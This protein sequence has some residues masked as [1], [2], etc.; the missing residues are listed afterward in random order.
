MQD[1]AAFR[2]K[3]KSGLCAKAA[4]MFC[5]LAKSLLRSI[6]FLGYDLFAVIITAI[7]AYSVRKL[8]L[9]ALGA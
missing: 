6:L 8:G 2:K 7:R 3:Y 4:L 1:R 9:V 5:P